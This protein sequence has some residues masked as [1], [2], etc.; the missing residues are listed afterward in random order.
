MASPSSD[1]QAAIAALTADMLGD[2]GAPVPQAELAA[3]AAAAREYVAPRPR[4]RARPG[5]AAPAV[6]GEVRDLGLPVREFPSWQEQHGGVEDT[7]AIL[8]RTRQM[9]APLDTREARDRRLLRAPAVEAAAPHAAPAAQA[10]A[11]D[12]PLARLDRLEQGAQ[13]LVGNLS[14]EQKTALR[15]ALDDLGSA[16]SADADVDP[17]QDTQDDVWTDEWLTET[18]ELDS[19]GVFASGDDGGMVEGEEAA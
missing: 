16:G 15:V 1:A 13:R 17:W 2:A 6:A 18:A 14:D 5:G 7:P 3:E 12:D 8:A 19:L 9:L 4:V 10:A 11:V